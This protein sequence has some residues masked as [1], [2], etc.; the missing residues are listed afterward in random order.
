MNP[1]VSVILPAHNPDEN[2]LARALGGLRAQTLPASRWESLLID[3]AS[4]RFPT[5]AWLREHAPENLVLRREPAIGLTHARRHGFTQAAAAAA[6]LVDDDNVLA[7]DYLERALAH[8]EAHPRVGTLGGPVVPEFAAPPPAWTA[9]FH[10]LLA[11]RDLGPVPIISC[12]LRP[13]GATANQYPLHAPVG[14]GMVLRRPAWEAWLRLLQAAA[15]GPAPIDRKGDDLSS[16]GDNDIVLAALAAGWETAYFPDLRL[17]HLIPASRLETAYLARLNHGIQRSWLRV[18]ARHDACP[19]PPV[20]PW[21]LPLRSARAWLR[22]R[23][24]RSP[25]AYVRWRGAVG[26]FE[27]RALPR[28]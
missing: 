9:E 25:A 3:N 27:G 28:A 5:S 2:R 22:H 21:T 24:W 23:P 19:W 8:L 4:A 16:S 15:S 7:P 18:L 6:V 14:A 26:H 11:L 12:G 1:L 13:P 17:V 20:P 10:S